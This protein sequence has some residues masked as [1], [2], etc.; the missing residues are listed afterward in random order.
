M[1]IFLE[2]SD[3]ISGEDRGVKGALELVARQNEGARVPSLA[4]SW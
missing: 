2:W 4:P 3:E 1:T